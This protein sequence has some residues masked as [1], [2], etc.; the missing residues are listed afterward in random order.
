[1]KGIGIFIIAAI[2]LGL[3]YFVLSKHSPGL[4]YSFYKDI[5]IK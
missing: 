2:A 4:L 5:G 1:M 3:I